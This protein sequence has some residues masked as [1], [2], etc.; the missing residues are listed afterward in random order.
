[1]TLFGRPV[2]YGW[3]VVTAA[4]TAQ[5]VTVG[6]QTSVVAVFAPEFI[7]EF[8]WT[9]TPFF[10]ADSIGQALLMAIG[11]A[12][13]PRI[14]RFGARPIMQVAAAFCIPS[15]FLMSQVNEYWHYVIVRGMFLVPA[16]SV[17]GFL[18]VSIS[19]SKWF[20]AK[21]GQA[22]GWTS[23]GVSM[24][25]FFWPS[26]TAAVL[27]EPLGWR[28][29]WMVLS[30]CLAAILIP[31]AL[32]MRRRP[33]DYG[34]LPDGGPTQLTPEQIRE[35]ERDEQ[36]SLTR[37]EAVRT[38]CFYLIVLIFGISVVGIFAILLNGVLYL[39]E[40]GLAEGASTRLLI[41]AGRMIA[42]GVSP[43]RA[44]QVS[45]VWPLTDDGEV[46]RSIEEVVSSI[47]ED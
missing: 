42:Q 35:A 45:I 39:R 12:L 29:A 26:F 30:A 4:F 8:G 13:G 25:G 33:E 27:I 3:I 24:A 32:L 9:R 7:E 44:C 1:M 38:K 19:V 11:F 43:R 47:F 40:H 23:M 15:L 2:F 21:R 16:A 22:L 17:A 10:A 37:S 41:Y 36:T 31:S 5:F 46:Q 34:M 28:T 18:V 6:V 14:D 20:V